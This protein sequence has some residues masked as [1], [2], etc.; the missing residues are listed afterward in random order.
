M[1][2]KKLKFIKYAVML[3]MTIV[4]YLVVYF[5]YID[6]YEKNEILTFGFFTVLSQ[7]MY[8]SLFK[9]EISYYNKTTQLFTLNENY[10]YIHFKEIK[11]LLYNLG[12]GSVLIIGLSTNF[13]LSLVQHAV[14][15]LMYSLAMF[16]FFI[17]F[18]NYLLVQ[19]SNFLVNLGFF[20]LII[21]FILSYTGV[22]V[23]ILTSNGYF[24]FGIVIPMIVIL[25][26]GAITIKNVTFKRRIND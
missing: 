15:L 24:I 21:P 26:I 7:F 23:Q 2:A 10:K 22:P 17:Y 14:M 19:K 13:T 4:F 3:S 8:Y 5:G 1:S 11:H 6:D 9:S 16:L 12:I 18:N 20:L 25:L